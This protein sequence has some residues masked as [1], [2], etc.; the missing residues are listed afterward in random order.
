MKPLPGSN[1]KA[2]PHAQNKTPQMQVSTMPST[3][4]LIDSRERAKP[5]SSMTKPT[6]MQNTRNAASSTQTVLRALTSGDGPSCACSIG[7]RNTLIAVSSSVSPISLPPTSAST[8]PRITGS[9]RFDVNLAHSRFKCMIDLSAS[10]RRNAARSGASR[11]ADVDVWWSIARVNPE[12]SRRRPDN[13]SVSGSGDASGCT[14]Q[15]RSRAT[16]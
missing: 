10:T 13:A 4:M 9:E 14:G 5:A 1:M 6:C 12:A 3:R 11:E 15:V 2:K 8:L 16:T 7:G